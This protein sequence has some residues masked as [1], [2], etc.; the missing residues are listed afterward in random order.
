MN[1]VLIMKPSPESNNEYTVNG[2]K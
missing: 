1:N 2:R